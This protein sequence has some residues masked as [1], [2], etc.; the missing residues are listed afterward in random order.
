MKVPC[1][2]IPTYNHDTRKWSTT[3]FN[4]Q[5]DFGNFLLNECFVEPGEY[6]FNKESWEVLVA[7]GK[8]WEETGTYT[9]F[10]ENSKA[11]YD[12]WDE[13]EIKNR[14]GVIWI[15]NGVKRY[16]T[17]DYYFFL[18][19]CPIINKEKNQEER[20]AT[21][22]DVQYH[23]MLYEKIAECFHLH[24]CIL[25]RRQMAFS[26]CHVAKSLNFLFF[27]NKKTIKWFSYD[28]SFINNVNGSWKFLDGYINHLKIHTAW[29]KVLDPSGFPEIQ[30]KEK[31]K[32]KG[33]WV[34][35]GN[36]ST[37]VAKT[38]NKDPK[39]GVGGPAFWVWYEEGGIA[40]TSNTTLQY[41]NSNLESGVE[42]VGS[43]C[44]G[45]SVGDLKECK[46]LQDFMKNPGL[47][48]F[49]GVP[50]KWFDES[51][52]QKT[53]GLFIP[54]QYGLPQ[55]VDEHGNSLVE[56][57]LEIL[58][59]AEF[60][61]FKA[62]EDGRLQDEPAWINL[63]EKDYI[64]KRSQNPKTIKEAFAFREVSDFPIKRIEKRQ[65]YLKDDDAPKPVKVDLYRNDSGEIKWRLSKK[66]DIPYPVDPEMEDKSG[67][68]LMW[69]PPDKKFKHYGG[70]DN[71]EVTVTRT[72]DSLF[73]IYIVRGASKYITI[74]EQ[75]N[76]KVVKSPIRIVASWTGRI[77][78]NPDATND[79]GIMLMEL[80]E[81]KTLA[82]RN[83]PN[84][85]NRCIQRGIAF[86][87][88]V[89]E[90][91]LP[92]NK[93]L[94]MSKNYV[95]NE[96]GIYMDSTGN[97]QR[98]ADKYLIAY[99]DEE[100]DCIYKKDMNGEY[101]EEK[102]KIFYGIDRINDY[103]LLEE[104]KYAGREADRKKENTD[105]ENAVR[106]AIMLAKIYEINDVISV[107]VENKKKKEEVK[108]SNVISFVNNTSFFGKN[109]KQKSINF[110]R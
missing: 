27:E 59:K 105:R 52:V 53:S 49:L 35:D 78:E 26:N 15:H 20:L 14:L 38:L 54:A 30:Q 63:P 66:D 21:F 102:V 73:S 67:V 74:D 91:E 86:K 17:R 81:A 101:T 77:G 31:I 10:P 93:E 16:L 44:I 11:Y 83:K 62:G 45:G 23:M 22:R 61:G 76:K 5:I 8:K 7:N 32:I 3:S 6:N 39:K 89:K 87:Y 50:T 84:F 103:W 48:Q 57:A 33:K 68:V 64:L 100:L 110:L 82:E 65:L 25:K 12:F 106:L 79:Y 108:K 97:K 36:F 42:K 9:D 58:H 1:K 92:F 13:E 24:S 18:N 94:D 28:E 4:T 95:N 75:G 34:S 56:K 107:V 85:I 99:M 46:P 2:N 43:F 109:K 19:Y 96:Y 69:E 88:L 98:E 40:P 71:V 60:I 51:G 90:K 41:L 70:V 72:S 80:Y 47:Y 37:L 55:A 29:D 104:C